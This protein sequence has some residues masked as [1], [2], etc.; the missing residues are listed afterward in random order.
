[1]PFKHVTKHYTDV[2][3]KFNKIGLILLILLYLHSHY[4]VISA[5]CTDNVLNNYLSGL[6]CTR[7][8]SK[9]YRL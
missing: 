1:M 6:H 3:S 2:Y 9:R 4:V 8:K 7:E 5:A